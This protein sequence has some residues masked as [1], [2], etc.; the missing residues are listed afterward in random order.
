[1]NG[2]KITGYG[3]DDRRAWVTFV[4]DGIK[5]TEECVIGRGSDLSNRGNRPE[6]ERYAVHKWLS[7]KPNRDALSRDTLEQMM[8][9]AKQKPDPAAQADE[10][11]SVAP[12]RPDRST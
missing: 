1:M 7:R 3:H 5:H 11:T 9:F 4:A 12:D 2:F 8:R 10:G 6:I